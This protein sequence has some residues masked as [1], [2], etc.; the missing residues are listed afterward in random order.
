MDWFKKHFDR[1]ILAAVGLVAIACAGLLIAKTTSF[2]ET[3]ETRNSLKKPNNN[4]PTPGTQLVKERIEAIAQPRDWGTHKGSLLVSEPYVSLNGADP[5]NPLD[6]SQPDLFP[7]V[8]N[9]WIAQYGLDFADPNLPNADPDAD[10]FSNLEEYTGKNDPTDPKSMPPFSTKLRLLEFIQ[11]P[12]RLK[13]SGSPD[14]GTY[15]INTM[16]LRGPTQFLK[17]G[18][19][20][21]GTQYKVVKYEPKSDSSAGYEKDVSELTVENQETGQKIVLVN[22]KPVNDPTVYARLKYLWDG[23]EFKVKKLE[24]FAIKPEE[25]VKYKL[26]DITDNE[27]VIEDPQGKKISV[28]KGD[29][30]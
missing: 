2:P 9:T 3:F 20:V 30:P 23:S 24:S 12:F 13:F 4:V 29:Q 14:V 16:D 22:D 11:V 28:P 18:E 19:M 5:V 10:K 25:T 1:V 6:P 26:I 7:N 21:A 15:S 8:P 27:A 17:I